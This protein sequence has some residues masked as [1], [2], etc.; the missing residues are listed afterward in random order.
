MHDCGVHHVLLRPAAHYTPVQGATAV[1]MKMRCASLAVLPENGRSVPADRHT[2]L[3]SADKPFAASLRSSAV[4]G[5]MSY[6]RADLRR[7][8][9]PAQPVPL[10]QLVCSEKAVKDTTDIRASTSSCCE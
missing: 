3:D 4:N 5:V 1:C 6:P 7:G 8:S 2:R 9:L 10:Q